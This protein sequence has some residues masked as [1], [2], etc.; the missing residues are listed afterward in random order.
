MTE[1][2]ATLLVAAI[3]VFGSWAAWVSVMIFE[4]KTKIALLKQEIEVLK[5]VKEVLS[6]IRGQLGQF[7]H[8]GPEPSHR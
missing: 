7:G 2:Y 6:D 1:S 4:L 3:S 5:E 8:L